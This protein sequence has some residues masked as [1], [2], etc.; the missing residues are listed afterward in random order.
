M[1]TAP[2]A[3]PP[4]P[5]IAYG[6]Y[7]QRRISEPSKMEALERFWLGFREVIRFD[8]SGRYRRFAARVIAAE[9]RYAR[10]Q[11]P[12]FDAA[13]VALRGRLG[14]HG[15]DDDTLVQAFA[16]VREAIHRELGM[17]PFRSQIIAARIMLDR[18][19]AEMHTGEGKTLAIALAAA[20]AALAGVPVHVLTANDYLVTR[21]AASLARVYHRLGLE[22][23][24]VTAGMP[25]EQRR[26]EYARSITYCTAKELVFD[27]LRDRLLPHMSSSPLRQRAHRLERD[28]ATAPLLRGL[29]LAIVDEADNVLL[30]EAVTPLILSQPGRGLLEPHHLQ[31]ALRLG[32]RLKEERHY[33]LEAQQ[34]TAR[35]TPAGQH[36]IERHCEAWGGLWRNTRFRENFAVLA[37][38]ALQCYHRD[39]DYLVQDGKIEMIDPTTGRI[40]AGRQWGRGLHQL[41][42]LKESCEPSEPNQTLAQ[43]TYQ[44]FFPRYWQLGG[45]S[46]TLREA[47]A[48]LW[49]IYELAITRVPLHQPSRRRDLPTRLFATHAAKWRAAIARCREMTALGRA[50]LIGTDSVA[51]SE[52]LAAMLAEAGV[53]A[54]VL[55]ARQDRDEAETVA[56]AGHPGCVTVATNMAGRGTDIPLAPEVK[57]RGGLHVIS[58]QL[59]SSAR[60][61]RQLLGRCARQGDPGSTETLLALDDP[62]IARYVPAVIRRLAATF[63]KR[64]R[65]LPRWFAAAASR[66]SQR[67]EARRQSSLRHRLRARD[68]QLQRWL[69]VGGPGE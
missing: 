11:D 26:R 68:R 23:G 63:E 13:L 40:A 33:H 57:A 67:L 15:L 29:C 3:N 6:A 39:R 47:R 48:E 1:A 53:A 7:P 19:L 4:M 66:W 32:Q 35:L 14:Q 38:N 8:R 64:D 42:E 43:I 54:S 36:E 56:Q 2:L 25:P 34:R 9:A 17:R 24:T 62:L 51:D 28:E 12:D 16:I 22:V 45:A 41:L 18:R 31:Q 59:N 30:D 61:D 27:Y 5:G 69:A 60:I 65:G 21:D 46:A 10:L 44:R 52:A 58:C 55:N 49:Q 37:L 20:S 50:V